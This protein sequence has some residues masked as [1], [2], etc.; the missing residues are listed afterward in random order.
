[1]VDCV[2]SDNWAQGVGGGLQWL[3]RDP[4]ANSSASWA[5]P[6]SLSVS[7]CEVPRLQL[8][9]EHGV[10][11]TLFSA[12]FIDNTANGRADFVVSLLSTRMC[13]LTW[14]FREVSVAVLWLMWGGVASMHL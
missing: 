13:A 14:L 2:F 12:Q 11:L 7:R 10:S 6:H 5:F 8:F 3:V 9:S 4:P 1:M